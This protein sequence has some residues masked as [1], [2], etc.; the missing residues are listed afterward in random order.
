MEGNPMD[1]HR[2]KLVPELNS[3]DYFKGESISENIP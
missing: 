3:E 2:R 1:L